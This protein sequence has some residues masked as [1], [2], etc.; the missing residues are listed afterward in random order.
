MSD[1]LTTLEAVLTDSG[2]RMF[3]RCL[4][5]NCDEIW[6]LATTAAVLDDSD[7]DGTLG[8][9]RE[10]GLTYVLGTNELIDIIENAREQIG[11]DPSPDQLLEAFLFCYDHDTFIQFPPAG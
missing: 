8:F 1:Q 2:K 11:D 9:A 3:D 6:N 5:L 7:L 4:Y 10:N